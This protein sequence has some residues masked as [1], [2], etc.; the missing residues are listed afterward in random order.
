[1]ELQARVAA[2]GALADPA[3]L[4]IVDLLSAGDASPS[5]LRAELGLASNL[6]AHHLG[7][8]E[9]RGIVTRHRSHADRRRTYLRLR[10]EGLAGLFPA[11]EASPASAV[12]RVVFVCTANSA[13]SQ[14]ADALWRRAST[15]PSTSAGTHPAA[16]IA[17]GAAAAARRHGLALVQEGPQALDGLLRTGDYVITVCDGAHEE[18]KPDDLDLVDLA[19]IAHWSIADPVAAGTAAAFNAAYAD[20]ADRVTQL[21]PRLERSRSTT[22]DSSAVS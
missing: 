19:G 16:A 14:L 4:R 6:L 1:M 5:E 22:T 3:R 9:E 13:R 12:E 17:P 7:V 10:P 8:L 2:L 21:A 20:I 11:A 18:L 15:I